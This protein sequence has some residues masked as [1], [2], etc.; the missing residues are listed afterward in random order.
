LLFSL[1]LIEIR[2]HIFFTKEEKS[3]ALIAKRPAKSVLKNMAGWGN[4]CATL[5][6]K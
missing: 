2:N 5:K 3:A 1:A 6:Q 4:A